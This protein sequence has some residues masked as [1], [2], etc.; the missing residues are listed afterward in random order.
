MVF[1]LQSYLCTT[2]K[3][4]ALRRGRLLGTRVTNGCKLPPWRWE[5]NLGS[6]EEQL[7]LLTSGALS[8]TPQSFLVVNEIQPWLDAI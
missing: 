2:R 8:S 3:P 5:P 7:V 4:D 6:L 1:C